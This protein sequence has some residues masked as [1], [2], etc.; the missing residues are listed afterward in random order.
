MAGA[1]SLGGKR[2]AVILRGVSV[3]GGG[4]G[5]EGNLCGS[6]FGST[7]GGAVQRGIAGAL[8]DR[9][10]VAGAGQ[11]GTRRA[12]GNRGVNVAKPFWTGRPR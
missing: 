7:G 8:D 11:D 5:E 2:A 6:G 3:N 12:E 4:A 10:G 9:G 1:G